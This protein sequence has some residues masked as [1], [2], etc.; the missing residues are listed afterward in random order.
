MYD[1]RKIVTEITTFIYVITIRQQGI[2]PVYTDGCFLPFPE[3]E[4]LNKNYILHHE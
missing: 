3:K 1:A 2:I 4:I